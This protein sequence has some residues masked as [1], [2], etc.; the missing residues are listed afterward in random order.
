M[1]NPSDFLFIVS[2][3]LTLVP[4]VCGLQP[5]ESKNVSYTHAHTHTHTLKH[6]N[7]SR[8][9]SQS[10]I[11]LCLE[12]FEYNSILIYQLNIWKPNVFFSLVF[13]LGHFRWKL[14][15]MSQ[16][17]RKTSEW[18][19]YKHVTWVLQQ[20]SHCK[21]AGTSIKTLFWSMIHW[22]S[23]P[24]I[25]ALLYFD[26]VGIIPLFFSLNRLFNRSLNFQQFRTKKNTYNNWNNG[27]LQ[28]P[29]EKNLDWIL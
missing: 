13:C 4:H 21:H 6:T 10:N 2:R 7:S 16:S 25:F 15:K 20:T 18:Q 17:V 24:K 14:H 3:L 12:D 28:K 5:N 26:V 22:I 1:T 8:P 9:F 27:K 19:V 23:E 11:S 29:R